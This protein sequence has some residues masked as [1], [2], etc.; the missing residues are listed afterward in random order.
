MFCKNKRLV[1]VATDAE[2][3][4]EHYYRRLWMAAKNVPVSRRGWLEELANCLRDTGDVSIRHPSG[5]P[6]TIPYVD[7]LM[8][9]DPDNRWMSGFLRSDP[10]GTWPRARSRK[11]ERVRLI[12]LYFRIKHP[13]IARHFGR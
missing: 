6:Y 4:S 8:G 3:L 9:D 2:L 7:E 11:L 5:Q 10:T 1:V 13:N 12:D